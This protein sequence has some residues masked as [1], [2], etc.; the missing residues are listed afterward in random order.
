[1]VPVWRHPVVWLLA[2]AIGVMGWQLIELRTETTRANTELALRLSQ[3]DQNVKSTRESSAKGEEEL[4]LL[5]KKIDELG[6]KVDA[7]QSQQASL[8]TLYNELL[9]AREDRTL[10]EI[11]QMVNVA[12]EQLQVTSNVAGA[13]SALQNADARLGQKNLPQH[14][15]L[16]KSLAHDMDQLKALPLA[17]ITSVSFQLESM[18]GRVEAL[19]YAYQ[20]VPQKPVALANA[21]PEETSRFKRTLRE[22]WNDI[23]QSLSSQ[24][25]IERLDRRDVALL[26]PQQS[27]YLRENLRL[28]LMSARLALL[29][30]N[31]KIFR[32]DVSQAQDWLQRYFD[33][34]SA[35]VTNMM[36]ELKQMQTA[37][38]SVDLPSLDATQ[39]L[40]RTLRAPAAGAAQ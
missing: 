12:S 16:R 37:K 21:A 3:A 1:M 39:T 9:S 24:I 8:E 28:R 35:P 5:Q 7:S 34:Q 30:R 22:L 29:Q 20:H 4:E 27:A 10:D 26:S 32:E 36:A 14:L 13:L 23:A 15:M 40:L 18:L 6:A 33:T 31:G 19:D 38:L 11:E 25:S 2:A 17:D